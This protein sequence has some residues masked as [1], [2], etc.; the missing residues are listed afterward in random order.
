MN[1]FKEVEEEIIA[2]FEE[3]K[4]M[5][6]KNLQISTKFYD[7]KSADSYLLINRIESFNLNGRDIW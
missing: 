2:F 6:E 7:R 5:N 1:N 3:F 4:A